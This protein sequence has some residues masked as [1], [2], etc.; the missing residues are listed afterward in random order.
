MEAEKT[1]LRMCA[2]YCPAEGRNTLKHV[3]HLVGGMERRMAWAQGGKVFIWERKNRATLVASHRHCEWNRAQK[4]AA[5]TTPVPS[6]YEN[7]VSV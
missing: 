6:V 4:E 2:K 1:Q 5:A 3:N 7:G